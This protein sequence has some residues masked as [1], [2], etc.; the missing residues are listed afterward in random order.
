VKPLL[1]AL[2]LHRRR[3][4]DKEVSKRGGSAKW[5][6]VCARGCGWSRRAYIRFREM[7]SPVYVSGRDD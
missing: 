6:E 5:L 2:G 4:V 1:C 7:A 3:V